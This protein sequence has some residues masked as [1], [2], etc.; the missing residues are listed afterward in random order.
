MS[1]LMSP[2]FGLSLLLAVSLAGF[3]AGDVVGV[4][5]DGSVLDTGV[6]A[7]PCDGPS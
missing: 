6:V 3:D 2:S 1:L 5:V 4:V 7:L